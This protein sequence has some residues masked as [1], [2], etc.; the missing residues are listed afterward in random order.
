MLVS[1]PGAPELRMLRAI[2]QQAI[3]D[4]L[5]TGA[6]HASFRGYRIE[7]RRMSGGYGGNPLIELTLSAIGSADFLD[8][9]FIEVAL[10]PQCASACGICF[11]GRISICRAQPGL[12]LA[13]SAR[14]ML[15]MHRP[16]PVRSPEN[17]EPQGSE[18]SSVASTQ[19]GSSI[20]AL[21]LVSPFLVFHVPCS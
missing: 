19:S 12:S 9:V 10:R 1:Q 3:G 21:G 18:M 16:N 14:L 11:S 20:P 13:V 17:R 5:R 4:A 2:A 7:A 6:D 15:V 8:R